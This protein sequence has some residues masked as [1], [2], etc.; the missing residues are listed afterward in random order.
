MKRA[1][2]I[3]VVAVLLSG[4]AETMAVLD[5]LSDKP[6]PAAPTP[7]CD[8]DTVGVHHQSQVCL[9]YDDGKYRWGPAR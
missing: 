2:A 6:Q 3:L 7:V 9:K 8:V 5:I 4:C 1:L